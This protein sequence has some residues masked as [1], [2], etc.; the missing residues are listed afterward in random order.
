MIYIVNKKHGGWGEGG[1]GVTWPVG[2]TKLKEIKFL[3]HFFDISYDILCKNWCRFAFIFIKADMT[4]FRK[5][6]IVF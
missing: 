1:V 4:I 2:R 5:K 3:E 6:K